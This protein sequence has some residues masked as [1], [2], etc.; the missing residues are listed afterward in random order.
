MRKILLIF[1]LLHFMQHSY[2]QKGDTFQVYF[3]MN[4]TKLSKQSADYIDH[5]IFNDKL[6]HGQKL[7]VLGYT[8]YVGDKAY[9]E[10]LSATRAKN[11][12]QYLVTSAGLE[13]KDIKL[14]MG[15]GKIDR[16]NTGKD[17]Y[18]RDRKVQII[19]DR[20]YHAAPVAKIVN[21]ATP[22][23]IPKPAPKK[24]TPFIAAAAIKVDTTFRL[25]ILFENNSHNVLEESEPE[26]KRLQDFM[27]HNKTVRIQI[28]GHI[29]CMPPDIHNDGPDVTDGSPVSW[30]RAKAVYDYLIDNGIEKNRLKYLGLGSSG[31]LVYPEKNTE[32]QIKNRRVEIRI[33]GK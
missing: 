13:Q 20:E 12:Q 14:C 30:S 2:A 23:P 22:K 27:E 33:L 9:N 25:E 26:L 6:I 5:L 1:S 32:D 31:M 8:D 15:K 16:A 3:S 19:I 17:G 11:V 18:E 7:I 29:C 24:E 4:E 28:E 10:T 21:S